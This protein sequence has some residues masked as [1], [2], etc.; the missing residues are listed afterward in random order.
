MGATWPEARREILRPFNALLEFETTTQILGS[1]GSEAHV[2]RCTALSDEFP[3]PQQLN[4]WYLNFTEG[5][6][7]DRKNLRVL[8]YYPNRQ[9]ETNADG[10]TTT[11]EAGSMFLSGAALDAE[12]TRAVSFTLTKFRPSDILQIFNSALRDLFPTIGVIVDNADTDTVD[13]KRRYELPG[14]IADMPD[15]VWYGS[16]SSGTAP[17][18]Q[19]RPIHNYNY[20]PPVG[21]AA[22]FITIAPVPANNKLRVR[23]VAP[24][25]QVIGE[26]SVINVEDHILQTIYAKSK[27]YIARE[28]SL[29]LRDRREAEGWRNIA[30]TLGAEVRR[31]ISEGHRT[32]RLPMLM[33]TQFSSY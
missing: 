17:D 16:P 21:A 32:E 10:T 5:N 25:P 9:E 12:V 31:L 6:N 18:L 26:N 11:Y 8:R 22:A 24:L 29:S 27:Q 20:Y 13:K 7:A 30:G 28:Q 23:G 1:A 33:P 2:A 3:D 14:G 15:R 19:W 4:S